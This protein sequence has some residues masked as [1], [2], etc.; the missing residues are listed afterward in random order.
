MGNLINKY[1]CKYELMEKEDVMELRKKICDLSIENA[2]IKLYLMNKELLDELESKKEN[3][4]HFN[5]IFN[6]NKFHLVTI[7]TL[8]SNVL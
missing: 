7:Y 5:I 1:T 3:H 2:I 8:F 4:Q 6:Q